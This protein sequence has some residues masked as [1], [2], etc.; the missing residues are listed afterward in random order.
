MELSLCF[1]ST[2]ALSM[3]C[4][5]SAQLV[6]LFRVDSTAMFLD[7]FRPINFGYG[8]LWVLIKFQFQVF[9]FNCSVC[10]GF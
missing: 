8:Q 3:L 1:D 5:D 6:E 10:L 2:Y 9:R 4:F 7:L